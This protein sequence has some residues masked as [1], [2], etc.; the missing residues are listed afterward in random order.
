M[1]KRAIVL[2]AGVTGLT[3]AY[4]I[5]RAKP[6]VE[7]TVLEAKDRIGGNIV[8]E[9]ASG[10]L[11]DGGP[12]SFLRTKPEAVQLC[13]ELGLFDDLI[14]PSEDAKKVYLVHEGKLVPM[15]AGM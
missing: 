12:D 14:T 4:A 8:T 3:A 11:I 10:F 15:P 7:L 9:R 2:G 5:L 6:D 13:K 1:A